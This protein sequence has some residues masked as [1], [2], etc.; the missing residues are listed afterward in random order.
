VNRIDTLE[1]I[2]GLKTA[3]PELMEARK[4]CAELQRRIKA[5]ESLSETLSRAEKTLTRMDQV[6]LTQR[7]TRSQAEIEIV[8]AKVRKAMK[9]EAP[10]HAPTELKEVNRALKKIA[11]CQAQG[12]YESVLIATMHL[13]PIVDNLTTKCRIESANRVI[14]S[15]ET[16]LDELKAQGSQVPAGDLDSVQTQLEKA[17]LLFANND[18]EGAYSEAQA[19]SRQLKKLANGSR[20]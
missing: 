15:C 14:A 9:L 6:I 1:E 19:S 7:K 12:D 8:N 2:P 13:K 18:Y 20:R 4:L 5:R 11:S 17:K 10:V 16:Q 3:P